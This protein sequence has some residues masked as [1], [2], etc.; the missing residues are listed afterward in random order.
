MTQSN[1]I[2]GA[3][4]LAFFLNI[5]AKGRL[6]AY[7]ATF[8]VGQQDVNPAVAADQTQQNGATSSSAGGILSGLGGLANSLTGTQGLPVFSAASTSFLNTGDGENDG[9]TSG[10]APVAIGPNSDGF[11]S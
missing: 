8:G 7:L 6:A 9:L 10:T 2:V 3:L 5:T 4:F 1:F 11:L